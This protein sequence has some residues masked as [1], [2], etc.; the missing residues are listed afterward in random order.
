MAKQS[1][2][3]ASYKKKMTRK[4]KRVIWYLAAL[5]R[6]RAYGVTK[7]F[8]SRVFSENPKRIGRDYKGNP[9]NFN[10]IKRKPDFKMTIFI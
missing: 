2:L 10:N 4:N 8:K 1:Y 6:N 3:S 5:D 7:D 9:Y